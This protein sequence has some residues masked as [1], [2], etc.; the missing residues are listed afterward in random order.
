[1]TQSL[2]S[3]FY[4]TR[5]LYRAE[6]NTAL[7]R[8]FKSEALISDLRM[9]TGV[10]PVIESG[11]FFEIDPAPRP[12]KKSWRW[13][14]AVRYGQCPTIVMPHL[15]EAQRHALAGW[16]IEDIVAVDPQLQTPTSRLRG[17]ASVCGWPQEP[18]L[19]TEP[20]H[21]HETPLSWLLARGSGVFLC[22]DAE[23]QQTWLRSCSSGITAGSVA[24]G[25]AIMKKMRRPIPALPEIR[26]YA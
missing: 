4:Q 9:I 5:L 17:L 18:Y 26:V 7:Q 6:W 10:A 14:I 8:M 23:Q 24:M 15:T 25:E 21:V 22:G 13:L 12:P 1:M 20:V 3:L 11:G 16:E 19:T 2:E